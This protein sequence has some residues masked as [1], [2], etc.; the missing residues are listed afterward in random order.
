MPGGPAANGEAAS[1]RLVLRSLDKAAKAARTYGPNNAVAVRF[2]QQIVD[3]IQNHLIVFGPLALMVRR[4]ELYCQGDVVYGLEE[5]EHLT[6]NLAFRL[7]G[8]GI[9]EL[10]FHPGLDENA[11]RGFVDALWGRADGSDADDDIV[12]RLWSKELESVTVV[13][14]E[15]LAR[16]P[17]IESIFGPREKG[18]FAP[19]PKSFAGV[20]ESERKAAAQGG[21]GTSDQSARPGAGLVGY[22]LSPQEFAALAEEIAAESALD[23][24]SYL[25]ATLRAI[26]LSESS[27]DLIMRTLGL[28]PD[29]M[30]AL[31]ETG[32]WVDLLEIVSALRDEVPRNSALE[33]THRAM[34]A[35]VL[36]LL[37]AP[38]AGKRFAAALAL[39]AP[40]PPLLLAAM[41]NVLSPR[42]LDSL[43]DLLTAT[44]TPEHQAAVV[45]ALAR[46]GKADPTLVLK[47]IGEANAA[48]QRAL[49]AVVLRW[50]QPA[51]ADLAKRLARHADVG[52]RRDA[53]NAFGTLRPSGDATAL[54]TF[55]RDEDKG[56]RLA[57]LRL[58][59]NG[60]YTT[61]P[62][63]WVMN[64]DEDGVLELPAGEKRSLFTAMRWCT[65]DAF[66]AFWQG[67]LVERGWKQRQKR[68]ESALI[69][70]ETLAALGSPAA[71]GALEVGKQRGSPAVKSACAAAL[72][73]LEE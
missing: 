61:P 49:L 2:F 36:S 71:R 68:E 31:L 59:G 9:R 72:A 7:F 16:A 42:A 39:P 57:A 55:V 44:P 17:E 29:A 27:S 13:T 20:I 73:S 22:D 21:Q 8:D 6:E 64:V 24:T 65:S 14:A 67:L 41:L 46:L 26:L 33:E 43:C 53:V 37:D 40:P 52:L 25:V 19:P 34:G 18:F 51:H 60:Q 10:R 30:G 70:V 32:R 1:A 58:L 62:D 47:R 45:D 3:E 54:V 5:L 63:P 28:L 69:A 23:G 4:A 38:E 12:T 11:I 15:D 35:R 50:S 66:V 48:V 56:V